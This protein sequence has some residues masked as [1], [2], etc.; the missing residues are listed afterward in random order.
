MGNVYACLPYKVEAVNLSGLATRYAGGAAVDLAVTL[1]P[2]AA[3]GEAHDLR[4]EVFGPD[5]V[6]RTVYADRFRTQQGTGRTS[7]P[8]ALNDAPGTWRLR[9]TD[10]ASGVHAEAGF[11]LAGD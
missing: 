8:L 1:Q 4:L 11:T 5:G 6:E 2:A 3:S 9:V 10:V 7:I